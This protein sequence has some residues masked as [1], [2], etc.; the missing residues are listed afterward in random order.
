M[1]PRFENEN[2]KR[3]KMRARRTPGQLTALPRPPIGFRAIRGK[4]WRREGK[5]SGRERKGEERERI[6]NGEV[7]PRNKYCGYGLDLVTCSYCCTRI[8][9]KICCIDGSQSLNR[10]HYYFWLSVSA[11]L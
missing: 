5:G 11:T 4:K 6:E 1:L 3:I 8:G 7:N 2:R 9:N 10:L